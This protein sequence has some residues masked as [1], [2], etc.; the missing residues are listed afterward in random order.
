MKKPVLEALVVLGEY[1]KNDQE[2]LAAL[3]VLRQKADVPTPLA[4]TTDPPEG[5]GG[6]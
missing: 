2:A 3:D 1:F 6:N 4:D 5:P